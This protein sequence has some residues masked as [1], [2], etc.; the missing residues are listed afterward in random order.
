MVRIYRL[1]EVFRSGG[2]AKRNPGTSDDD[3]RREMAR[4]IADE[5]SNRHNLVSL[6]E[7]K[8]LLEVEGSNAAEFECAS[9][10]APIADV[11]SRECPNCGSS[12][13]VIAASSAEYAYACERCGT[14]IA[15]PAAT[16]ACP[17][18]GH[19]RAISRGR[20]DVV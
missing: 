6:A 17:R 13:A 14:P 11:T 19:G 5:L 16:R 3:R 7:A 18:C 9:C 4:A 8:Q 2:G 20:D 12:K 15:N 1:E 10:H